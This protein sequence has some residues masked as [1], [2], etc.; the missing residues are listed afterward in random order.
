MAIPVIS[1]E[2]IKIQDL[3][4]N[5]ENFR[6]INDTD[7]ELT[8]IIAMFKVSNRYPI[9]MINLAEDISINGLNPFET[10]IV[11]YDEEL[12]KYIVIDGNRRITCIKL[13][14]Q[15]KDNEQIQLVIPEVTKIYTYD[16][17]D[18]E[19]DCVVYEKLHE[20]QKVLSK[21][22]QDVNNGIGRK[23]WDP[24]AK[25][26]ANSREGNI[27]KTYSI[28]QFVEKYDGVK[29]ELLDKMS[30]ARWTSKLERVVSFKN[31]KD[32]YNIEFNGNTDILYKDT[33]EQVYK[34]MEKLI[35]DL[36]DLPATGNFRIRSDF[37]KY[38][39]ELAGEYKTQVVIDDSV[40]KDELLGK[41][42]NE[43]QIANEIKDKIEQEVET[44]EDI[45]NEEK[46]IK[47]I[48]SEEEPILPK[49][50]SRKHRVDRLALR[51]SRT[52][53]E[54]M[55]ICLGE[56]GKQILIELESL[57]CCDYPNATAALCRSILEYIVK[58]WLIDS[59]HPEL[60]KSNS[61]NES[62][63]A[64]LNELRNKKILNDKQHKVLKRC[65]NTDYFIDFLNSCIHADATICVQEKALLDG[66]KCIRILIELYIETH[67]GE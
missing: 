41:I 31:F 25:Q 38:V 8:A 26:K 37:D 18:D 45:N 19:I 67:Q 20:A 35:N 23:P 22:H 33:E 2:R 49:P 42:G 29:Q 52:Y 55:Y 3:Y 40:N 44:E 64:C 11:W 48:S 27:S 57:N 12:K 9:E 10:P 60:F 62:Y 15:Y 51:L 47:E 61:L 14:G 24:Y 21:I 58:L 6:Y 50:I 54:D 4:I 53:N 36:I 39:Q 63:N 46:A 7:D 30:E 28:I 66:W 13:M 43:T 5:P 59:N 32:V 1:H 56:K 16:Y 65:S 34:M 17:K